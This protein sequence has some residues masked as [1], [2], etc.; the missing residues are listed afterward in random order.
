MIMSNCSK[1]EPI[2]ECAVFLFMTKGVTC[3][4]RLR[5]LGFRQL[6]LG[7]CGEQ[8]C[9]SLCQSHYVSI[10]VV[11]QDYAEEELE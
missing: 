5:A 9:K 4:G 10:L 3:F 11:F 7:R 1:F 6:A 2:T 8:C